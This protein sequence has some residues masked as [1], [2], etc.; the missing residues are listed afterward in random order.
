MHLRGLVIALLFVHYG[1]ECFLSV[2]ACVRVII[3]FLL[4]LWLIEVPC[5]YS[6]WEM[7]AVAVVHDM[8][9]ADARALKVC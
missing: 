1:C 2:L 7:V 5:N 8:I 3:L 4:R 9:L 6:D